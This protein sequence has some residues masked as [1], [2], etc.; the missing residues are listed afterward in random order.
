MKNFK[1]KMMTF[2]NKMKNFNNK[3]DS[4]GRLMKKKE[5]QDKERYREKK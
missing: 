2:N 5:W 1:N 3:I 4:Y